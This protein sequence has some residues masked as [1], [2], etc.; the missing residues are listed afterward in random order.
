M[1]DMKVFDYK[2]WKRTEESGVLI[3]S[4]HLEDEVLPC[5]VCRKQRILVHL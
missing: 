4:L 1:C 2:T 3:S 5:I